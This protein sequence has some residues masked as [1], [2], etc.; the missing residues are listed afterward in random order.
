MISPQRRVP[1]GQQRAVSSEK[2]EVTGG[3]SLVGQL[4]F[5]HWNDHATGATR[6]S[7]CCH[8]GQSAGNQRRPIGHWRCSGGAAMRAPTLAGHSCRLAV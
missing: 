3:Q 2:P 6:P 4:M 1:S 8:R 5:S 7:P